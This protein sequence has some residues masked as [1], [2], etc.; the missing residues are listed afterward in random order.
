[1]IPECA[2]HVTQRGNNRQ[3]VFFVDEDRLVYLKQLCEAAERFALRIEGY[4]LM[5]N[6]VHPVAT[7]EQ[8][9]SLAQALKRASP[10]RNKYGV[11]NGGPLRRLSAS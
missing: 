2:D 5:T 6:R 11:P 7:P 1:V 8:E 3:D 4:C 10:R 9:D